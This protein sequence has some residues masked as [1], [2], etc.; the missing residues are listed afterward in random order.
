MRKLLLINLGLLLS[1][2]A[3]SQVEI[4]KTAEAEKPTTA[5]D[6]LLNFNGKTPEVHIGLEAMLLPRSSD[7]S[8]SKPKIP[9]ASLDRNTL[10][11]KVGEKAQAVADFEKYS[12]KYYIVNNVIKDIKIG[13]YKYDVLELVEKET[14]EKLYYKIGFLGQKLVL[15]TE[16]PL[17]FLGYLEKMKALNTGMKFISM[18]PKRKL[19]D[20]NTGKPIVL[21]YKEVVTCIDVTV[22]DLKE[23]PF[24]IPSF[25]FK[26][27][28]GAEFSIPL[29]GFDD[30]PLGKPSIADF[31]EY[32]EWKGLLN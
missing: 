25:I 27:A 29:R 8:T 31:Y 5:Y 1:H 21:D 14:K 13:N 18:N 32:E 22:L 24:V 10:F 4:R 9:N 12:N 16:D 19:Y 15:S 28:D 3:F 20:I 7:Y 6:S 23:K 2:I 17:L 26:T 11:L 30:N